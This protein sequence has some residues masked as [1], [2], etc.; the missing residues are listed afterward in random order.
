MKHHP[1]K[2]PAIYSKSHPV[3]PRTPDGKFPP[4]SRLRSIYYIIIV[5][6]WVK[7]LF[8]GSRAAIMAASI[9]A[10]SSPETRW[11]RAGGFAYTTV[12]LH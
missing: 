7:S 4:E 12:R 6:R 9:L 10:R 5:R 1:F 8:M 2:K 11:G 3:F